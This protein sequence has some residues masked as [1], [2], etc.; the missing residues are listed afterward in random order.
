MNPKPF[1]ILTSSFPFLVLDKSPGLPFINPRLLNV[2]NSAIDKGFFCSSF[3]TA[4][5]PSLNNFALVG[6][7]IENKENQ[8]LNTF[9][10]Y[11]HSQIIK[12]AS[13]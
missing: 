3:L 9:C 10:F 12:E 4:A 8:S 2:R 13:K 11:N 7:G 6:C 1:T 5:I